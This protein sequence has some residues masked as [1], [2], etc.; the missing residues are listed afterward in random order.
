MNES[1]FD[2]LIGSGEITEVS[3]DARD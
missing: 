1:Q 2:A 3:R